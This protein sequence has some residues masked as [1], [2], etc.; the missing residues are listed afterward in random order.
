MEDVS[1]LLTEVTPL[2]GPWNKKLSEKRGRG[3]SKEK[4]FST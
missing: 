2:L 3:E 1:L 4:T